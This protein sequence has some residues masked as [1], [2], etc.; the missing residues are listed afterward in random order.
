MPDDD[1]LDRRSDAGSG[2]FPLRRLVPLVV[3]LG[4]AA[5]IL[6]AGWHR[7]LSLENLV[8]HRA[9]LDAVI[10]DHWATALVTFVVAYVAVVSLSIPGSAA[11]TVSG[12]VLFG[13]IVG[14]LA[15]IVAA[16][17]GATLLFLVARTAFSEHLARWLGP[18]AVRLAEGFREDAFNYLLFLRLVPAFPFFLVNLVP[19]LAGVRVSTFVS[20]TAIGIVPITFA[21]AFAGAG[22]DSVIDAQEAEYRRCLEA[23]RS[24]CALDFDIA[25]A[26]TP[27]LIGALAALGV[28]AL[29]P[30]G[31]KRLRARRAGS[32][33]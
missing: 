19:A 4:A 29:I 33:R 17:V 8:R 9:T 24:G 3:L 15:S 31:V 13:A 26:I 12:G 10:L 2:R 5:L 1:R 20:A 28:A 16:T 22:L 32:P 7:E 23:R 14:G 25:A 11:M 27:K 30:V 6:A 18:R 21:F